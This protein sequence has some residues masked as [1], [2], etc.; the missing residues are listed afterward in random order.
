MKTQTINLDFLRKNA[1]S[2]EIHETKDAIYKFGL[3]F[4]IPTAK[5]GCWKIQSQTKEELEA[6]IKDLEESEESF[7]R[8][9]SELQ[10]SNL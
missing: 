7:F 6:L 1:V 5:T 9:L 8:P 4:S 10:T 2:W 3:Y